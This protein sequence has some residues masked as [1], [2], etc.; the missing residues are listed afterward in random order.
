MTA[1][2]ILFIIAGFSATI[3][4]LAQIANWIEKK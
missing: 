4:A 3:I 1:Y 2:M